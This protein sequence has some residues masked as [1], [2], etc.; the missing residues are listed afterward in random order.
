MTVVNTAINAANSTQD[1]FKE[2][3]LFEK[4]SEFCDTLFPLV[5]HEDYRSFI[6]LYDNRK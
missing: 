1:D 4:F 5:H 2:R 6:S 3:S